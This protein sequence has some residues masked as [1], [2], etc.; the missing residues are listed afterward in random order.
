MSHKQLG[1]SLAVG[2]ILASSV[3]F[4]IPGLS[5]TQSDSKAKINISCSP[6]NNQSRIL[7]SSNPNDIHSQWR[8]ESRIGSSWSLMADQVIK[9]DDI[10]YLQGDLYSPRGGLVNKN[11]FVIKNEWDCSSSNPVQAQSKTPVNVLNIEPKTEKVLARNLCS[12][13]KRIRTLED[14]RILGL[15]V[16]NWVGNYDRG[17]I[18]SR[19]NAE[20]LAGQGYSNIYS[21]FVSGM[22]QIFLKQTYSD[23][24]DLTSQFINKHAPKCKRK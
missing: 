20:F 11:V 19:R 10:T 17:I 2:L 12:L 8:G 21:E 13:I 1:R 3:I 4:S 24:I 16:Y 5:Q 18:E 22:G 14:Q 7:S 15:I 9:N 6:K 23:Q